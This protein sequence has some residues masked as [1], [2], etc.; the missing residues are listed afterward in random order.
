MQLSIEKVRECFEYDP[1][2]G[3]FKWR[4]RPVEHFSSAASQRRW[5]GAHAGKPAGSKGRLGYIL[6]NVGGY[7]FFAHKLAWAYIFG[8]WPEILDHINRD[9]G[10]NRI[11]NL[12]KCTRSQNQHNRAAC[13]TNKSGFKGVSYHKQRGAWRATIYVNSRQKHLGLFKTPDAAHAAY[14]DA[15][16]LLH[17][18]FANFGTPMTAAE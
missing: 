3:A 15:A 5:N 1:S 9:T 8:E 16:K 6:I 17:A 12:R 11:V 13:I 18:D 4:S 7:P 10:D 2:T 14:C